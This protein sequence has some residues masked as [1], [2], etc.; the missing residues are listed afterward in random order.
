LIR[1]KLSEH[2]AVDGIVL[3]VAQ[4]EAVAYVGCGCRKPMPPDDEG[5][6]KLSL[7]KYKPI[8]ARNE[9]VNVSRG[10]L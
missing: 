2:V 6:P 9:D 1:P 3:S 8:A 5:Y 10:L 7:K 4:G